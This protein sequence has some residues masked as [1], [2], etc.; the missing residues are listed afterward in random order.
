M[1]YRETEAMSFKTNFQVLSSALI[2][3]AAGVQY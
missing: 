1:N 2:I 3:V